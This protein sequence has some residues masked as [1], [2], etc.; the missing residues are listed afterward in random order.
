M[1]TYAGHSGSSL[2]II[3]F[4]LVLYDGFSLADNVFE[5]KKYFPHKMG[6]IGLW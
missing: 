2:A 6:K 3:L 5:G 4:F 1:A